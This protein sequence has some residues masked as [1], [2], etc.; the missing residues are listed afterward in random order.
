VGAPVNITMSTEIITRRNLPHWYLPDATFFVTYRL[1]GSLPKSTLERLRKEK[2]RLL[3]QRNM[4]L[5][6]RESRETMHKRLFKLYDRW[7]DQSTGVDWL[8]EP[9]VAATVRENLYHHRTHLYHLNSFS[10]MPNH[11]HVLF[12]PIEPLDSL[13]TAQVQEESRKLLER[14]YLDD[15]QSIGERSDAK[16]PLARIMHSLKSYTAHEA[17]KLLGRSGPFWQAESYDHWVRDEGELERIVQYIAHNP[18]SAGLV[19]RPQDWYFSSCHD[20]FLSDGRPE[21]WLK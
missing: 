18:V 9:S 19:T 13:N 1:Y 2:Q 21:A 17:N 14:T 15:E 6:Q 16:S 5:P 8:R 7:L 3:E 20:R 12:R 11:V 4:N 10:I